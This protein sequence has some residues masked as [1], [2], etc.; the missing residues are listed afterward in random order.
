MAKGRSTR[1]EEPEL[2]TPPPVRIHEQSRPP[3]TD[4]AL[5]DL[6]SAPGR[7]QPPGGIAIHSGVAQA[8]PSSLRADLSDA[9][10]DQPLPGWGWERWWIDAPP[11][12]AQV[13]WLTLELASQW[14]KW[15]SCIGP[16][17]NSDW[18]YQYADFGINWHWA[19]LPDP[20]Y[21]PGAPASLQGSG[22]YE[23]YASKAPGANSWTAWW[24]HPARGVTLTPEGKESDPNALTLLL[25]SEQ[26]GR[27]LLMFGYQFPWEQVT[28][29][30]VEASCYTIGGGP[31]ASSLHYSMAVALPRRSSVTVGDFQIARGESSESANPLRRGRMERIDRQDRA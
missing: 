31:H 11:P 3:Q 5:K 14:W 9:P 13:L 20:Y 16:K 26:N 8:E 6:L 29:N 18:R 25:R 19:L 12:G 15:H 2:D 7:V 17:N 30:G 23:L 24:V 21:V 10:V 1:G 27:L 28:F 4:E 22:S